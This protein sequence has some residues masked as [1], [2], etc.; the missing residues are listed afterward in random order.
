[1]QLHTLFKSEGSVLAFLSEFGEALTR[2]EKTIVGFKESVGY[3]LQ[4]LGMHRRAAPLTN[5]VNFFGNTGYLLLNIILA[6]A[7]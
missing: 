7:N 3:F 1:M 6:N 5:P 2:L 4:G